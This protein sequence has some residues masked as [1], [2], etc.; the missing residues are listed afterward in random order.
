MN[1]ITENQS[2][3]HRMPV[4]KEWIKANNINTEQSTILN[5]TQQSEAK[6]LNDCYILIDESQTNVS[7]DANQLFLCEIEGQRLLKYIRVNKYGL[8]ELHGLDVGFDRVGMVELSEMI[9]KKTFEKEIDVLGMAFQLPKTNESDED[10]VNSHF[11]EI[12][13]PP[14]QRWVGENYKHYKVNIPGVDEQIFKGDIITVD[15]DQKK[16]EKGLL[17]LVDMGEQLRVIKCPHSKLE[18]IGRV[19]GFQGAS[20][21]FSRK[22]VEKL[23]RNRLKKMA[24]KLLWTKGRSMRCV[25]S[26]R[27]KKEHRSPWFSSKEN[28]S[29][30][31]DIIRNKGFEAVIY[32]A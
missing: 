30:A 18:V 8:Y 11:Q 6:L 29:K 23:H 19:I 26:L 1:K 12:K 4:S 10:Q 22:Q 5:F 9:D 15:T 25:V 16:P 3:N 7:K 28:A 2:L 20:R 27:D 24:A 13:Q 31:L 21:N 32:V 17:Y 14:S